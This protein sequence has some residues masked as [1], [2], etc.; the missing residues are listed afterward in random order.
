MRR[1]FFAAAIS[2]ALSSFASEEKGDSIS[3]GE[4]VVTGSRYTT[5]VRHLPQTVTVVGRQQLTE[6]HR[7]NVLPTLVEQVPGLMATSRGMAGYGVAAGGSGGMM[8]RGISSSAGQLM[9]LIDGNPQYNGIFGHPIADAYQTMMAERVEVVRGPSSLLYGSN[10]M[11]GV[12]NIVTRSL[13]ADTIGASLTLA[14]GSWGTLESEAAFRC[15]HGKLAATVGAQYNRTDNHRPNMGF[16]QYGGSSNL[17]YDASPHW[18]M[19][20][21]VNVTHFNASYPGT[22]S[23]PMLE[24]DQWITRGAVALSVENR[25]EKSSGRLSVYDNFGRHKINDGYDAAAGTPQTRLF[26]SRDALLG[27]S[28]YQSASLWQD[29]RLTVGFDYQNI[30]GNAYYTDRRTGEI[31]ETQNKQSARHRCHEVAAY[32]DLRQNLFSW[33]TAEAGVRYDRHS[34]VGGEWVPQVGIVARPL[35]TGEVKLMASKGFR[36]PTMREMYLYPPS[37]VDLKPER[38]WNYE[39][40]WHQRLISNRLHYGINLFYIDADNIIQTVNRQNVNT[41]ELQNVGVELE[42]GYQVD[43]H[44]S[45]TTNHSWLNM[46][47]PVVSA[48]KYKGYLGAAM[49]YG[50]WN[51]NLGLIQVCG[52]YTAIGEH[53]T[54]ENFTLLN[55]TVAYSVCRPLSLWLKGDNLLARKYEYIAGM[56][57]PRATFMAGV[58]LTF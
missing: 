14:A 11:G 26:R 30:Y 29:S 27:V 18:S 12:V 36:N 4:V 21:D 5:D 25:Y 39:L 2:I 31:I 46:R 28:F 8:L 50:K 49:N 58:D 7:V 56:P 24:A 3:L 6:K 22:I 41:G 48:P 54:T 44:W 32:V 38:L 34:V 53:E 40:S 1:L 17:R 23:T 33:L 13:T 20:A 52:L 47:Y 10:A 35:S 16:E 51:I 57:M 42:V 55:A 19:V 43:S 45:L 15:R 37:N 9:V